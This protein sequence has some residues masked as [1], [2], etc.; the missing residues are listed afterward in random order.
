MYV[1][2]KSLAVHCPFLKSVL[3]STPVLNI[4][5]CMINDKIR[6]EF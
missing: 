1:Y 3:I 2:G 4:N 5:T 6:D